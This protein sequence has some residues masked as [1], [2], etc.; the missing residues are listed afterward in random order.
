MTILISL[1][2]Y[3]PVNFLRN[4][5]FNNTVTKYVYLSDV[6]FV[7]SIGLHENLKARIDEGLLE[8]KTVSIKWFHMSVHAWKI[9][10]LF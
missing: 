2:E 4:V 5:A 3:Y 1:Q 6:D 10:L 9:T 8:N 7:P